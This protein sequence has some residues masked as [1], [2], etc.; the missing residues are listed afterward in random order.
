MHWGC[1]FQP[2][3]FLAMLLDFGVTRTLHP[4]QSSSFFKPSNE[5]LL[6]MRFPVFY[7]VQHS[8]AKDR[9]VFMLTFD[10]VLVLLL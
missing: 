7:T 8:K 4:N 2:A 3:A 6:C 9:G 1:S 5:L 10:E